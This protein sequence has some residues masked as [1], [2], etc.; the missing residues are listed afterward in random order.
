MTIFTK[1]SPINQKGLDVLIMLNKKVMKSVTAALGALKQ[2]SIGP[3]DLNSNKDLEAHMSKKEALK[4][5]EAL[6]QEMLVMA[7]KAYN[8]AVAAT[9]KLL[10]NLLASEPLGRDARA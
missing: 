10:R 6:A 4:L 3:E 9:Y 7:T 8:K 2:K 1:G 5:K